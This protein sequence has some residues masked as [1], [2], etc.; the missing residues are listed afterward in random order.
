MT[1]RTWL[2]DVLW[3]DAD[4]CDWRPV[5]GR[6]TERFVATPDVAGAKQLLRWHPSSALASARRT[7]DDRSANSRWRDGAAAAGLLALGTFTGRRRLGVRGG[8][9][10]VDH[11]A[12]ALDA[13]G[14]H[15]LVMCGPPRANQKPV[16]QLHDRAGRTIAFVKVAW[17]DLT[18]ELLEAERRS[19]ETLAGASD[20]GFTVP[21]ILARGEFGA[22]TWLAIGPVG[23]PHR[24]RPERSTIDRLAIDVE[25]TAPASEVETEASDFVARLRT[26]A[27]GLDAGRRAVEALVD[28]DRGRP[29]RLAA[30]HGDF[31]PWNILSGRPQP[32]VWDW[33]RYERDVPVGA[34]R[35]HHRFQI[36]VQRSRSTVGDALAAIDRELETI[37]P[38]LPADRRSA[39]LD[40]YITALLVRYE[41]DAGEHTTPRLASRIADL[42]T[43]LTGRGVLT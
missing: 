9:S 12:E 37:L 36:A 21:P 22:A 40:W 20:R 30:S 16:V 31:V 8:R 1:T 13:G 5:G 2:T 39:H 27:I 38:D 28:R 6:G 24:E 18:R 11:V 26:E 32:A 35:L 14:A 41:H 42:T 10:L 4:V 15:G 19:L 29:L 23:V 33:E 34:D 7:S 43:V 3:L 25:H 17:N